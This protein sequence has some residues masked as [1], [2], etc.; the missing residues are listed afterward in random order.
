MKE[1]VDPQP[2]ASRANNR[3]SERSWMP[4]AK[5]ALACQQM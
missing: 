1:S 5:L 3:Q 4:G 2:I